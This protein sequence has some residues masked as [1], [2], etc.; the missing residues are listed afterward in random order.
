M[1]VGPPRPGYVTRYLYDWSTPDEAAA[2]TAEKE[3]PAVV[4][5]AVTKRDGRT[6]VRVAPIT[7]RP[8]HDAAR[9][10][11]IPAATRARLGLDGA[12]SWV[13]LDHANEFVWPGPDIRPLPGASPATITYGPLPPAFYD[14]LKRRLLDLLRAGRVRAR[15]RGE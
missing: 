7:L 12:R 6:L 4:V 15:L 14:A 5:L 9:A 8:P 10:L 13:I 3:R 2:P 11:E 1:I